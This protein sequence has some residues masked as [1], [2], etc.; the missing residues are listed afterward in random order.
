MKSRKG[1]APSKRHATKTP[2]IFYRVVRGTKCYGFSYTDR[3]GK[4]VRSRSDY[5]SAD[6]AIEARSTAREKVRSGEAVPKPAPRVTVREL[7]ERYTNYF[8]TRR[9]SDRTRSVL[10]GR[11]DKPSPFCARYGDKPASEFTDADLETFMERRKKDQVGGGVKDKHRTAPRTLV[12]N[13]TINIEVGII[14]CAFKWAVGKKL[15]TKKQV[16]ELELVDEFP[17]DKRHARPLNPAQVRAVLRACN[18]KHR[19]IVTVFLHTGL[20]TNEL[21]GMDW[22]NVDEDKKTVYILPIKT[23]QGRTV[24]LNRHAWEAIQNQ[25]EPHTGAVFKSQRTRERL[26]TIYKVFRAAVEKSGIGKDIPVRDPS[27]GKVIRH[28][29]WPRPH[30]LRATAGSTAHDNGLSADKTKQLLGHSDLKTTQHYLGGDLD[31]DGANA[32]ENAYDE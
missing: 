14:R 27:T 16:V 30:D 26:T 17:V 22:D 6:A 15:V 4:R 5:A 20:R 10:L 25:P 21:L 13:R 2:G 23:P 11:R 8:E 29:R 1:G 24:A 12:T 32:L 18:P 7:C 9:R 19:D 31:R 3:E 28:E